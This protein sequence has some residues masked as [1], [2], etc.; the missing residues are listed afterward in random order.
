MRERR[1]RR[2]RQGREMIYEHRQRAGNGSPHPGDDKVRFRVDICATRPKHASGR[3][4]GGRMQMC[5]TAGS[6]G[7][8]EF[9]S[10][11]C[12]HIVAMCCMCGVRVSG[13]LCVAC[14]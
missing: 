8:C 13:T 7:V 10:A 11:N 1:R 12:T 4:C 9:P 5:R 6:C 2:R 14:V 3:L